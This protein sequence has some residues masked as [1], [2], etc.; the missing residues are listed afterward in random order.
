M[1]FIIFKRCILPIKLN[2]IVRIPVKNENAQ[3]NIFEGEDFL[4]KNNKLISSIDIVKNGKK[5]DNGKNYIELNVQL[6]INQ[7]GN[8]KCYYSLDPKAQKFKY[9]CLIN[10]DLVKNS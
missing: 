10:V 5:I 3:I 8:L 7:N 6:E 9:E 1:D 4:V 2:K